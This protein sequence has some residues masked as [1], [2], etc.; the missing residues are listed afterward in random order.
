MSGEDCRGD[1]LGQSRR[2]GLT[3]A[4]RVALDAHLAACA[5]CRLSRDVLADFDQVDLVD[6]RDGARIRA[7]VDTARAVRATARGRVRSQSRLRAAAAAAV[8]IVCG[9]SASAAVWW[10]RRPAPPADSGPLAPR[11]GGVDGGLG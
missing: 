2:G 1:L 10:W 5:S 6:I 7:L 9:G 11:S 4:G 3:D 8:L